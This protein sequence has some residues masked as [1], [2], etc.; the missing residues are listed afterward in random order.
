MKHFFYLVLLLCG[1]LSPADAFSQ[2]TKNWTLIVYL[3]G[4]DLESGFAAGSTDMA[5]MMSISNT[6]NVNIVVLTG[7]ADK[8]GW[9][10]PKSYLIKDGVRSELG[11]VAPNQQ[12]M[13]SPE[14]LTAFIDWSVSNYPA[15]NYFLTM[16][17][18]GMSI[19]GY[20]W[21]DVSKEQFTIPQI[22][23][24]IGSTN[25]IQDGNMFELIGFDACLMANLEAQLPLKDFGYFFVASEETEPG[26]GWD[27]APIIRALQQTEFDWNGFDIGYEVVDGFI[28][29]GIAENSGPTTTL[30][31]TDLTA[32][33]GLRNKLELLFAKIK[34]EGKHRS[35]QKARGVAQEYA[36][37]LTEP[38]Q[39]EDVVDIGDLMKKLKAKDPSLAAE[40]NAVLAEL[41]QVVLYERHST[42]RPNSTGMTMFIPHN[43][44][45]DTFETGFFMRETYAPLQFSDPIESY[46]STDYY[47][48]VGS[49]NTPPTGQLDDDF[50]NFWRGTSGTSGRSVNENTSAIRV[51]H[52]N[53]LEEVRVVLVEEFPGMPDEFIILGS[54]FPD[55]SAFVA[56]DEEIFAYEFD[57]MWLGINGFPA[58]ISD[59]YEYEVEDED[60][61]VEYFAQIQIPALL[62]Y[63]NDDS[64]GQE[65]MISYR[66]D[67]DF[68]ITME[69]I[70]PQ[71]YDEDGILVPGKERINLVPGDV[72]QLTY[73]S[74]N[75]VTDEEFFVIDDDAY[76]TIE[77]GNDDL[78]LE[79]DDLF[80]GNYR[81]GF[82]LTDHSQND[83]LIFDT[84]VFSVNT[85]GTANNF[86]DNNI[87]MFPNPA[88][89]ELVVENGNFTGSSYLVRLIDMNGRQVF[90][91]SYNQNRAVLQTRN[92]PTGLYSI[93]LIVDGKIYADKVVLKN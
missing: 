18:H 34:Q 30:S 7:A 42:G 11:F 91:G 28:A 45:V 50:G 9:R 56:E 76:I 33:D 82:L 63:I 6:S 12:V 46:I 72:V 90:K 65:I 47:T 38:L 64:L 67:E 25:F 75:E 19:R 57:G 13:S 60:G 78:M 51:N 31:V 52:A 48:A 10:T 89:T 87:S 55:T 85:D 58:Y 20:G 5:E 40:A 80:E 4:S 88:S 15:T 37:S 35:L 32:L 79:Y 66:Y 62:N 61:N 74:F 93:E 22:A 68:N 69:G 39:S 27:Y 54:T 2:D 41:D 77:N 8:D 43:K 92:L 36:Q 86:A 44:M 16:W 24:A 84:K 73:E 81:I 1:M 23:T 53:D 29:Q 71:A 70:I 3:V 21:D 26:H 49:D 14:N 59:I 83:T 17:N